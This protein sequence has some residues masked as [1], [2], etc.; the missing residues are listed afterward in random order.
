MRI[1][2][3]INEMLCITLT[4]KIKCIFHELKGYIN[5]V[6]ITLTKPIEI[7][8]HLFSAFFEN[9]FLIQQKFLS[10]WSAYESSLA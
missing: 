7:L 6:I 8:N 3:E 9:I 4:Y 5:F 2:L 10:E 1:Q